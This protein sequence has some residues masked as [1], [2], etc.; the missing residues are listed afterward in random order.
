MK[1]F[2][3]RNPAII[4]LVSVILTA[5][6]VGGALQYKKLPFFDTGR[7][8]SAYF[9]EAGGLAAG[10]PVQVAGYKVGEVSSVSLDGPQVVVNFKVDKSIRLGDRT[11]A[12]VKTKSLLGSKILEII[13]RGENT[14][15]GAIPLDRTTPAY[16]LPDALGDLA[17]TVS[18][19]NTED[20]NASLQT[21]ADTFK[22]TPP[23]LAAAVQGVARFSETLGQRDAQ[24]RGL[25]ENAN[26]FTSVLAKRTDQIVGLIG[27]TNALL[28]QLQ[29]QSAALGQIMSNIAYL[30]QQIS[31]FINDNRTTLRPS[32]DRLNGVLRILN[33]HKADL[34]KSITMLNRYALSLGE[35]V[36]SG[37]FFKA[38]LANLLPGQFVQPFV[39]AAFSDLGLDPNTLLPSQR[40]D[41]P[42]GQR[43]TPPLPMPYP[44]TGQGGEPRLNLPDA[45]TGNP[46]DPGCGPPGVPLP[47]PTGCYPYRDPGPAPAPGGP[48]PG[49]PASS[50]IPTSS[51]PTPAP[52][53]VP[54]P[55]EVPGPS[56]A[57][58]EGTP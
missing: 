34:Q 38:Y 39:D 36:G 10:A 22:D 16:Q 42:T 2:S 35:S 54:A 19:L 53:Y 11:E 23:D 12:S 18:G 57:P 55:G 58:A 27:D 31:G 15:N 46:G 21:L 3:E 26:K 14:L 8:Y 1:T 9:A 7:V 25:L 50:D 13:P 28:V 30:T 52:V 37:P 56:D 29:T 48:P 49:P 44:R 17:K 4:G 47:G 43:A 41:P 51:A 40:I 45:I 32:L 20:L 5:V 6:V 24:L 33:N